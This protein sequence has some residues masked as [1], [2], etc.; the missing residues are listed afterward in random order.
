MPVAG[1]DRVERVGGDVS[2]VALHVGHP[3]VGAERPGERGA[4]G[5]AGAAARR[6]ARR[7]RARRRAPR[8][9]AATPA[10]SPCVRTPTSTR[11]GPGRPAMR[12]SS[13]A[14]AIDATARVRAR[15]RQR[16]PARLP[17]QRLAKRLALQEPLGGVRGRGQQRRRAEKDRERGSPHRTHRRHWR[18]GTR[19]GLEHLASLPRACSRKSTSARSTCRRSASASLSRSSP[20]QRSSRGGCGSSA[21]RPTGPTRRSSR[22]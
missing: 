8:A 17:P 10:R 13:S 19:I 14:E 15:Q 3:R 1:V 9:R 2:S 6:S 4:R 21:S 7:P 22:P 16:H 11:T 20:R 5:H 18:A 12:V